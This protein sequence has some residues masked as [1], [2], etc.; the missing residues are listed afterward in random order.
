MV[1]REMRSIIGWANGN[2]DG[3]FSPGG[4]ISNGYGIS[5]ARFKIAPDIKVSRSFQISKSTN[6]TVVNYK[7]FLVERITW[8]PAFG[9]VRIR[10]CSLFVG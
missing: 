7:I 2:G 1:L 6:V 9:N 8:S 5:C 4:S 3:L 10:R